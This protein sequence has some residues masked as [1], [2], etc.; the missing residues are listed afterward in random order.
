MSH[1]RVL[2]LSAVSSFLL[3]GIS[4]GNAEERKLPEQT[5]RVSA[6][7]AQA[8]QPAYVPGEVLVQLKRGEV[9]SAS[10]QNEIRD[11]STRNSVTRTDDVADAGLILLKA[12]SDE[13]VDALVRRLQADPAV[14]YA[15]PN[16]LYYPSSISSNDTYRGLLW[17][18]D[19]TG[20]TVNG[21]AGSADADIDAPAAWRIDTG[22]NATVKVAVVD[23]GVAYNHS[24]LKANMW[25][26]SACKNASGVRINGCLYG[27]DFEDGDKNP[28]PTTSSHGTHVAGTIAAVK[29]NSR[30][31]MGV[32]PRA[33]IMAIKAGGASG[34]TSANLVKSVNFARHNGA[35]VI[36]ASLGGAAASCAGT[37]DQAFY[38]AIANFPGLFV[39]AAGNAS[40]NHDGST[41][42]GFPAD[43]GHETSCWAALDNVISVAA[44]DS[45]DALA[46]FSD[47]GAFVDVAAPGVDIYSTEGY[48]IFSADFEDV[49]AGTLGSQFT[50]SGDASWGTIEDIGGNMWLGADYANTVNYRDNITSSVTSDAVDL[51]GKPNSYLTFDYSCDAETNFDFLDIYLSDGSWNLYGSATGSGAGSVAVSLNSYATAAFATRFTWTTDFSNIGSYQGCFIDNM[52]VIN[53]ASSTGSFQFLD[54]TSMAT[55]HVA[56]LAALILGYNPNLRA[57]D[58]KEIIRESGDT[59]TSLNGLVNTQRRINAE[60]ALLQAT[61]GP[62]LG[63]LLSPASNRDTLVK[64]VTSGGDPITSFGVYTNPGDA[65]SVSA[66]INGNNVQEVVVAPGPG[67]GG[68]VKAYTKTGTRLAT[69]A[70]FGSTFNAG[71]SIAAGDVNGDGKDEIIVAPRTGGAANVKV[72]RYVSGAFRLLKGVRAFGT[73]VPGGVTVSS[74]DV[75]G[76]GIDEIIAAPYQEKDKTDRRVKVYA[77]RNGGLTQ[78]AAKSPY[79]NNRYEGITTDTA[80]LDGDGVDEIVVTPSLNAGDDLRVYRYGSGALTRV[81]TVRAVGTTFDGMTELTSGDV[82]DDGR[83][84]IILSVRTGGQ[85][86]VFLYK[87]N[88]DDELTLHD[89]FRAYAQDFTGGVNVT[90][91]DVDQDD[92]AEVITAP[93]RGAQKVKVWNTETA[94]QSLRNSFYAFGSTFTGGVNFAK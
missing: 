58:V 79:D 94:S 84:E 3:L 64:R 40:A 13:S 20:Q 27:Y 78:L 21:V 29:N 41:Y 54:G 15:Q 82:N 44:T 5:N 2:L 17:G 4:P 74:G 49:A 42:F 38:N 18:L 7:I 65:L 51:S 6:P 43:Y 52:K 47:Y 50:E 22:T 24:D 88:A 60:R 12:R 57:R 81:D 68:K 83:D 45:D 85:P 25:N 91:L 19:N 39:A 69:F 80:D 75:N 16:F 1:Q 48:Q 63:M 33:K 71:I 76:D 9:T 93:Y 61:S 56:G 66:D 8:D 89:S 59:L 11:L 34:F 92:K 28:L 70:P 77:Y 36:N 26:G 73:S 10:A 14:E 55:P 87:L 86:K 23:T 35:Q 72:F 31:I 90:A 32:A 30:G 67:Q 37:F 62:S 46:S 53:A